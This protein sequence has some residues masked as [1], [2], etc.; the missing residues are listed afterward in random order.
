MLGTL[1]PWVYIET[2]SCWIQ[3]LSVR[4][5]TAKERSPP[6]DLLI[7]AGLCA[8]VVSKDTPRAG[9]SHV[10]G[11]PEPHGY[12]KDRWCFIIAHPEGSQ[13]CRRVARC[14]PGTN[15]SSLEAQLASRCYA[16]PGR[17]TAEYVEFPLG[18]ASAAKPDTCYSPSL[19]SSSC[20]GC[21]SMP[22]GTIKAYIVILS[23]LY[24]GLECL[25]K[26]DPVSIYQKTLFAL[27]APRRCRS[28]RSRPIISARR[29]LA[30]FTRLWI[31]PIAHPRAWAASS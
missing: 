16:V 2:V 5:V 29:F 17:Q 10:V 24:L 13:G 27:A 18:R 14:G 26:F 7:E 8:V 30:R 15:F 1:L 28:V 6:T 9:A 20:A 22:S 4:V 21:S 25:T 31:V 23:S 3:S 12:R 19:R 11:G